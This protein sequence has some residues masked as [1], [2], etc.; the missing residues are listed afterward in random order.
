MAAILRT[1]VG[2]AVSVTTAN[3]IASN[4][5]ANAADKLR[6]NNTGNALLADFTLTSATWATAPVG[7]VLQLV[8]VDRDSAGNAG[9]AP[10]SSMLG[11]LVGSFSPSPS[12]G[13]A[14]TGWIMTIP[15]VPLTADCDY[16]IYN[17]GTGYSLAAGAVL[18]AQP[19][20]PGA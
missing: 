14:S 8:A 5:Y 6:I 18:T 4:S 3:A 17:N 16:W 11:R 10:S 19:W 1:N 7:G 13:N 12:T 20:S 2:S 15:A 9:P